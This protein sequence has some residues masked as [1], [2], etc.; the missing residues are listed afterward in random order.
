MIVRSAVLIAVGAGCASS[1]TAGPP[2]PAADACVV[3]QPKPP[4]SLP[5][6]DVAGLCA[7][8][9][10][11]P[12]RPPA[13]TDGDQAS[14]DVRKFLRDEGYKQLGWLHDADWRMTGPFEGCACPTN[15][16]GCVAGVNKGPHPAVRIYYSPEVIDWMCKYRRGDHELPNAPA[17]PDGAMIVKEMI[18]PSSTQL[19]LVPG[20]NKLWIAPLTGQ[21]AD[22]YDRSYGSWTILLKDHKQSADGWYW[23]FFD[24]SSPGNPPIWDRCAFTERRTPA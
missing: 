23:A 22:S 11:T 2:P 5:W 15:A 24:K 6:R 8:P 13:F 17:M 9:H 7:A 21:P 1:A 16:P 12:W 18:S 20:S 10:G 14:L 19:A 4:P 3:A